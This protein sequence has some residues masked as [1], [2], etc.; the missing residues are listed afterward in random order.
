MAVSN[1]T[2][3]TLPTDILLII[4]SQSEEKLVI[5]KIS[6]FWLA[7][8]ESYY[9]T[10]LSKQFLCSL[11]SSEWSWRAKFHK[12]IFQE[13][14]RYEWTRGKWTEYY[15]TINFFHH[16]INIRRSGQAWEGR[17]YFLLEKIAGPFTCIKPKD[18]MHRPVYWWREKDGI[19][20]EFRRRGGSPYITPEISAYEIQRNKSGNQHFT[21]IF[22]Y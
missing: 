22:D 6:K 15:D 12:C 21:V 14:Y 9:K 10:L 8:T 13:P 2:W 3:A 18:S 17:V 1:Q 5:A 4:F 7:F 16:T 19:L 11:P 20:H